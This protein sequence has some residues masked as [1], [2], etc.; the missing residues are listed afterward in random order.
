MNY[1]LSKLKNGLRIL[2]T[3]MPSLESATL[4][5]WVKTGS[6]NE[7]D[8]QLGVSHFLEHMAFKGGIKY[9]T[10]QDVS[11]A[12]DS[13]GG[14]FNASTSKEIT[15]YYIRIRA[16]LI[17]RACDVLSD[18]ILHPL[19][20]DE[21]II[22]EKGVILEEMKMYE[23]TPQH[24]IWDIYEQVI[25]EGH[26]LGRDI[27][28]TRETVPGLT[29]KNFTDY[30]NTYYYGENM[31][32]TVAG[33]VKEKE[34]KDLSEKYFGELPLQGLTLK[35]QS[36]K[37]ET[38]KSPKKVGVKFRLQSKKTEQTNFV[39]GYPAAPHGSK[40]RYNDAILDIIL[41]SGMSSRLFSEV[42][43]KRGLAYSVRSDIDRFM[44]KGYFAIYA[45][46][47][48]KKA[49]EA[50]K[51]ILDQIYGIANKNYPITEKEID[52]AKEYA[53]GHMALSLEDTRGVNAFYGYEQLL[54]NKV[55]TPEEVFAEI[56]K[57]KMDDVLES[58]KKIFKPKSA[59]LA[60]IGPYKEGTKFQKL[61]KN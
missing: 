49:E 50:L 59:N 15:Q 12:V 29:A 18:M 54:L 35:A 61:V 42:R 5:V 19:L 39:L 51:V 24:R 17:E 40:D 41:G 47:D 33:G 31:L 26:P 7:T 60:I 8:K 10:A 44:D 6:R 27:I 55:R 28:G 14:E 45:G 56:D 16:E 43:E 22:R 23:D 32:I 2:T 30:R 46:T 36:P 20:K 58:A 52:K 34:I 1:N 37:G 4:T 48:P 9:P 3:P 21:D 53:K 11:E 13:I 25:F 57:V 38:L